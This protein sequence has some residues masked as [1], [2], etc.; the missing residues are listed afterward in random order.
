V[1][2]LTPS[3]ADI[4]AI[5]PV[6][7]EHRVRVV[8]IDPATVAALAEELDEVIAIV[9]RTVPAPG[10]AIVVLDL[11]EV[12]LLS[13]AGLPCLT[14]VADRLAGEGHKLVPSRSSRLVT[15]VLELGGLA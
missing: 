10:T 1:E 12:Q 13:V 7:V 9:H 14:E 2:E 15:K 6:V 11:S 8:E 5:L 3:V 4:K